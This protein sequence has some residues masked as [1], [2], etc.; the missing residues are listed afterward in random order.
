MSFRFGRFYRIVFNTRF[1]T[2]LQNVKPIRSF[3]VCAGCGTAA[4]EYKNYKVNSIKDIKDIL[5][6]K[7]YVDKYGF[8]KTFKNGVVDLA[9]QA[10]KNKDYNSFKYLIEYITKSGTIKNIEQNKQQF[11]DLLDQV[12]IWNDA[13]ATKFFE[14]NIDL[15]TYETIHPYA[16]TFK[17][18]GL[19]YILTYSNEKSCI[20]PFTP[21]NPYYYI[22]ANSSRGL[23][24]GIMEAVFYIATKSNNRPLVENILDLSNK[25]ELLYNKLKDSF[26]KLPKS[27]IENFVQVFLQVNKNNDSKLNDLHL[28]L[29]MNKL[30]KYAKCI[31]LV[32]PNILYKQTFINGSMNV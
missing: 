29:H 11:I 12:I 26:S 16:S 32:K 25:N 8:D 27:S 18:S 15:A 14:K 10:A 30:E 21:V 20:T 5:T 31:P 9:I 6:L 17:K 3:A 13:T 28:Y 24:S 7:I 1:T 19:A 23:D 22:F 2:K 4:N